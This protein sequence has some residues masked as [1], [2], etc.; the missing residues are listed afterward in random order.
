V[1][2]VGSAFLDL[3]ADEATVR[4]LKPRL[5]MFRS[6][7]D[8]KSGRWEARIRGPFVGASYFDP[9]RA[10]AI[11]GL[12]HV[13]AQMRLPGVLA[14]AGWKEITYMVDEVEL[15]RAV[16]PDGARWAITVGDSRDPSKVD[17]AI[18]FIKELAGNVDRSAV[19]PPAAT[20]T[21]ASL[22]RAIGDAP[23]DQPGS[24]IAT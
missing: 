2:V 23:A 12:A 15:V 18:T 10:V 22:I 14:A 1:S 7:F 8:A 16:D 17:R 5:S 11:S 4:S 21:W 6:R 3:S 24:T 19:V 20:A 9:E 13:L